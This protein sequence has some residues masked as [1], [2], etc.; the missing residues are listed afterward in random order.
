LALLVTSCVTL[1][2]TFTSPCLCLI[3]NEMG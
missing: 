2:S 1:G 3:I